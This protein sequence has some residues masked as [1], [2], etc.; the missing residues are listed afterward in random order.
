MSR[1][2]LTLL[3]LPSPPEGPDWSGR[4]RTPRGSEVV[5]QGTLGDRVTTGPTRGGLEGDSI[6]IGR[7][8]DQLFRVSLGNRVD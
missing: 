2:V 5:P 3:P 6:T 8:G 1:G 7:T 4:G